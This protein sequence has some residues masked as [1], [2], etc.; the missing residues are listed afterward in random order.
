LTTVR[1]LGA[2][3]LPRLADAP[4]ITVEIVESEEEPGGASELG[5]PTVAPAI[6]NAL[7]ALTGRRVRSLPL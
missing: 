2:L 6:A 1:S 3:G 5:V 4:E 7:F